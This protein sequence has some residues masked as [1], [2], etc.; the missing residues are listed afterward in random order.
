[1]KPDAK[2]NYT[3]ACL[4]GLNVP[5]YVNS[6]W[7]SENECVP[8]PVSEMHIG[9]L[10]GVDVLLITPDTIALPD[11]TDEDI[12]YPIP[13]ALEDKINTAIQK[14]LRT[15]TDYIVPEGWDYIEHQSGADIVKMIVD[16]FHE[17]HYGAKFTYLDIVV[18]TDFNALVK[19]E[20]ISD[21]Q[22]SAYLQEAIRRYE[23]THA[24]VRDFSDS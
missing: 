22:I 1:M 16:D 14:E 20:G 19:N 24:N 11:K 9:K 6:D 2:G 12:D 15:D 3:T 17:Y 10:D 18:N 5:I 4:Q 7:Q 23:M 8:S 21:G 13:A